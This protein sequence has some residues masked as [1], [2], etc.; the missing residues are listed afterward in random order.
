MKFSPP[1]DIDPRRFFRLM[2]IKIMVT[3]EKI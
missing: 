3:Y 1:E 2:I